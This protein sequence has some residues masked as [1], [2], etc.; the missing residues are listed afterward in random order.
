MRA[1]YSR[2]YQF[3]FFSQFFFKKNQIFLRKNIHFVF[4]CYYF[5]RILRSVCYFLLVKNFEVGKYTII[6]IFG[7]LASKRKKRKLWVDDFPPIDEIM[8][9]T[10]TGIVHEHCKQIS[11]FNT[12][13][14]VLLWYFKVS[15]NK[16]HFLVKNVCLTVAWKFVGDLLEFLTTCITSF[17]RTGLLLKKTP[18]YHQDIFRPQTL[19]RMS[20]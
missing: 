13:D 11:H 12:F 7:P 17:L 3:F 6:E 5:N 14:I 1:L 16:N 9:K 19:L 20:S 2:F 15:G 18:S 10:L 4:K 8:R